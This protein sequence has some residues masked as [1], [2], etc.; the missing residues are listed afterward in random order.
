M[1][2]PNRER[3]LVALL[4]EIAA[5]SGIE[6]ETFSQDW[7]IHLRRNGRA[8]HVYGYNFDL[9]PAAAQ[10]IAC[11]KT[12]VSDL[13]AFHGLPRVEHRL[14]L[15]PRLSGYVDSAGNWGEMLA[16]AERCGWD[17][18][19]KSKDGTG[20][21]DVHHARGRLELELAV[22]R[23]FE[24]EHALSLSPF[25][26]IRQEFRFIVLDGRCELAYAK[27]RP[28][29]LGDGRSTIAE[30]IAAGLKTG[31]MPADVAARAIRDHEP[32]LHNVP[33]AGELIDV[34]WKHNLGQ[35]SRPRQIADALRERLT[36]LACRCAGVLNLRFA[37]V[38]IVQVADQHLV[39]EVNSG[40]MME[41]FARTAPD[42]REIAK[43]IYAKAV[44]KMLRAE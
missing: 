7:I 1:L 5:D 4:R 9:N 28:T 29:V 36:D 37:S 16:F 34:H 31:E 15:H 12:A 10:L 42:G 19:C 2:L 22:Q 11:D 30:L 17:V 33:A 24:S 32:N 6:M 38:D 41:T 35:G 20:G 21:R 25:L 44:E 26:N 40:I 39:L 14:F 18:V 43:R 3:I 23:L 27:Q 13:L 8:R